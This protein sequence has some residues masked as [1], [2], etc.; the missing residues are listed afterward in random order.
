M[1]EVGREGKVQTRA[2]GD[3]RSCARKGTKNRRPRAQ[4]AIQMRSADKEHVQIR[5]D[6]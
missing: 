3:R 1:I 2:D 5:K 6:M 4:N